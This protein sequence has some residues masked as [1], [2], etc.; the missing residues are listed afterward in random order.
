MEREPSSDASEG[1]GLSHINDD[2]HHDLHVSPAGA[3]AWSLST[4]LVTFGG[5]NR[6]AAG[7]SPAAR[8]FVWSVLI[9]S[10]DTII[11]IAER[12]G[13][14]RVAYKEPQG[15]QGTW[16]KRALDI[17]VASLTLVLISPLM[18]MAAIAVRVTMGAP[19][20]YKHARIGRDGRPF[21]CLKFRT[22]VNNAPEV[23]EAHL[24]AN[25][26]A[27]AE[28]NG[29][30]KLMDDPRITWLGHLFRRSSIDELPQIFNVLR[31][32]MSCVGPRP[33]VPE[34]LEAYGPHAKDYLS[35]RPGLT[36]IWQVSGRNTLSYASRVK[37]D[38]L[39]VRRRSL[40]L[41]LVLLVKT[42]PALMKFDQTA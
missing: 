36:G 7:N 33:I 41:D 20:F 18:I 26:A 24:A 28:W 37:L 31:G 27:A 14:E 25:P 11:K 32:D 3:S 16:G 38:A 29:S 10:P 13:G 40:L 23:L 30:R 39:Y 8:P 19:V 2:S 1:W 35:V 9:D 4:D 5:L 21:S 12:A 17:S 22:M 42:I 34:E 6:D 15:E